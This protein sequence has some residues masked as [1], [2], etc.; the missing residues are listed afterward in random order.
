[1]FL[2]LIIGYKYKNT[3]A[4]LPPILNSVN[5]TNYSIVYLSMSLIMDEKFRLVTL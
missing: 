4:N 1:M 3:L 5:G 2:Y